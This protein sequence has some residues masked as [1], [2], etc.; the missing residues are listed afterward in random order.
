MKDS[1]ISLVSNCM[2]SILFSMKKMK[3]PEPEF[4]SLRGNFKVILRKEMEADLKRI[5]DRIPETKL[6]EMQLNPTE[7]KILELFD[8]DAY[9]TQEILAKKLWLGRTAITSNIKKLK[10]KGLI[11]EIGTDRKGYWKIYFTLKVAINSLK[12]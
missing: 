7:K 5:P 8:E 6:I 4:I 11:E 10:D 9:I 2:V 1:M 3:L 12:L